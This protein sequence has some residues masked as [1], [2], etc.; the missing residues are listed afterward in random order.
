MNDNDEF[1]ARSTLCS[2]SLIYFRYK[3]WFLSRKLSKTKISYFR[4]RVTK[5]VIHS[6]ENESFLI[7]RF[8]LSLFN[9]TFRKRIRR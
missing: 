2:Y 7:K 1:F 8:F 9:I 6:H 4:N 3:E 5:K